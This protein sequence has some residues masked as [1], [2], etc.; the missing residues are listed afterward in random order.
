MI[1]TI[2]VLLTVWASP[3]YAE[4]LD[5]GKLNDTFVVEGK[6]LVTGVKASEWIPHTRIL[7]DGGA[8]VGFLR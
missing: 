8:F 6:V 3:C 5:E 4:E 1:W 2:L 7:V